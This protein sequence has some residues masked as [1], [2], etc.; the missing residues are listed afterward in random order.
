MS[1]PSPIG[2]CWFVGGEER[3]WKGATETV[4][5]PCGDAVLGR[6][7]CM[8]E[9]HAI[10]TVNAASKA[11]GNG[12]GVWPQMPLKD[13]IGAIQR[14]AAAL[15]EQRQ[16]LADILMW[17][18]CKTAKD[19]LAE[20]D[21][22][23]TYI[24]QTIT[25]MES[26][27][28]P[29]FET[30][31]SV[32]VRNRRR[33]IGI[34]LILGPMNYPFNE[35]YAM[36]IPALLMGNTVVMKVPRVG[37]LI[38]HLTSAIFAKELPPGVVNFVAGS[39][40]ATIPAV[41]KSGLVD[42]FAFIGGSAAASELIK[43]H[44]A[45]H[46]LYSVLGLEAKNVAIVTPSANLELAAKQCALG[47]FSFNGQRCTAIKMVYAHEAIMTKFLALFVQEV[48]ALKVG[49]PWDNP[50]VTP[51]PE[52][53]AK[54]ILEL[55]KDA[56]EK[57]AKVLNKG[58]GERV[59]GEGSLLNPIV[60][61][62]TTPDMKVCQVEQFG[63]ICPLA[64]F[65]NNQEVLDSVNSSE[66]GQQ[67]SIFSQDAAEIGPLVDVLVNQVARVNINTQCSRG[68]DTL[69]FTGRKSSALRTLSVRDALLSFSIEALTVAPLAY[70]QL[71][72][73]AAAS[74]EFLS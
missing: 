56:L 59:G 15:K 73:D 38:H 6:F 71:L 45:P 63:P 66:F 1:A 51:V 69:P 44:P 25:E 5:S 20:I 42:V 43:D 19:S 50:N 23:L 40:R 54:Y 60:V 18:I 32:Y 52:S 17:E 33:P 35:T 46:R 65:K 41:M 39:S 4:T 34:T 48:E 72:L 10:E 31:G 61:Y 26:L 28:A 8:K 22:T 70:Q 7:A 24:A 62:P 30:V 67:A 58:G 68:P 36:L 57:G 3:E 21:R 27:D 9:E 14:I 49:M 11:W 64:S 16:A 29:A 2:P 37:G 74:S 53:K 47:A 12:A 55:L 13:R